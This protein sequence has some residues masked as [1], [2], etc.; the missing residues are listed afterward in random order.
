MSE[1]SPSFHHRIDHKADEIAARVSAAGNPDDL[2]RVGQVADLLGKS[3]GWLNIGRSKGY[4]PR[5]CKIGNSVRYRRDA[6]VAWLNERLFHSTAQYAE[7]PMNGR[8]L[9]A[10]RCPHCG[11][12][13]RPGNP[14][15]STPDAAD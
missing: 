8:P 3:E 1:L 2:L 11:E 4:G 12:R 6:V 9:S 10:P 7:K 13:L 14:M 5:F 15:R